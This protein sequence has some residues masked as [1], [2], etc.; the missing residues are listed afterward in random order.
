M[1]ALCLVHP[2]LFVRTIQVVGWKNTILTACKVLTLNVISVTAISIIYKYLSVNQSQIE[3][4]H[5][6]RV[7]QR[8]QK[9]ACSCYNRQ[10]STLRTRHGDEL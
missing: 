9:P 3:S 8:E 4:T 5:S 2:L 1:Y 10:V 6:V 7:C